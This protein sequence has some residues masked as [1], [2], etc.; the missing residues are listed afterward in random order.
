MRGGEG[1]GVKRKAAGGGGS[2]GM[3]RQMECERVQHDGQDNTGVLCAKLKPSR[4][5]VLQILRTDTKVTY[6]GQLFVGE[7]RGR[8]PGEDAPP[9]LSQKA[10]LLTL[11][12]PSAYSSACCCSPPASVGL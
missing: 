4:A 6:E 10:A 8:S 12:L 7:G 2:G 1:G 11:V 3:E 5:L 9:L